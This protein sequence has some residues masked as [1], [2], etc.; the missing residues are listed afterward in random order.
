MQNLRFLKIDVWL[1]WLVRE[2]PFLLTHGFSLIEHDFWM[3]SWSI[4]DFS[5]KHNDFS[6]DG[7][8]FWFIVKLTR[9]IFGIF[10]YFQRYQII[11]A[12]R[13]SWFFDDFELVLVVLG[14]KLRFNTFD[15][16][17]EVNKHENINKR[18]IT[19]VKSSHAVETL[20]VREGNSYH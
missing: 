3:K 4:D 11:R 8:R 16:I 1:L 17:F 12:T 5:I 2:K 9:A 19:N 7:T 18:F 15:L 13:L 20:T 14:R 10:R 6:I